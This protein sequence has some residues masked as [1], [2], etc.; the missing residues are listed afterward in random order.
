MIVPKNRLQQW[1]R[2]IREI[3]L[4]SDTDLLEFV[5]ALVMIIINPISMYRIPATP[6]CW[7]V[8]GIIAGVGGIYGLL[9]RNLAIRY[10]AIRAIW[11]YLLVILVQCLIN[12]NVN[13]SI[14]PYIIQFGIAW[15][16]LWK[17]KKQ[18][19]FYQSRNK[20]C[21]KK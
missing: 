2:N 7:A 1:K 5:M 11:T 20:K 21:S 9:E 4:F 17:T 10:W 12:W 16:I 14:A 13:V 19:D 6:M 8:V 3:Y 15:L 18:L